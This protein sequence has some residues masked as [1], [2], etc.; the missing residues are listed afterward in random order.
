MAIHYLQLDND[1]NVS[2]LN[3]LIQST[4]TVIALDTETSGL[5]CHSD[6]LILLQLKVS[7]E[8]FILNCIKLSKDVVI[9][10]I[11]SLIV[12]Q[13][14]LVAHN[15]K[16]DI[17]FLYNFSGLLITNI[18]D[19]MTTEVLLNSGIGQTLYSL[20]DLAL[21]YV[22]EHLNKEVRNEFIGKVDGNVTEN[23]IHYSAEDVNYLIDIYEKQMVRIKEAKEEKVYK[24]EFDVLPVIAMMEYQGISLDI[25]KWR[26][27][28][29]LATEVMIAKDTELRDTILKDTLKKANPKTALEFARVLAIPVTTKKLTKELEEITDVNFMM[30]WFREHFNTHSPK[31]MLTV[32]NLLG[33]DVSNTN[34]KTIEKVKDKHPVIQIL[35]DYRGYAK[36]IENYG[37]N[38]I[39]LINPVTNKLHTEYLD[40]G[41]VTGRLSSRNPN[42][43]NIPAKKKETDPDYREPFIATEGFS[44]CDTD[45]S[46]QEFRL[47]GA[48]SK[49]PLIIDA[50][51]RGLDMH[52]ATASLVFKK[53]LDKI[54][55][56]ER[57]IGK[58]INFAILYGSTEYGLKRNLNLPLEEAKI[59]IAE[60][61]A[62]YPVLY[63]FRKDV[64]KAIWELGYSVTLTG[65]RKYNPEKPTFMDSDE[66]FW[67]KSRVLREG[68]NIL[69]QGTAADITK[70]AMIEIFKNNPFGDKLRG[71]LQVHDELI[72]EIHDSILE[73]GK[74]Y[75]E[76]MMCKAEQPFLGNIPAA[77][78]SHVGKMWIH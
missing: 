7:G 37:E 54:T 55:K 29:E 34:E 23:G 62:G 57:N 5:D 44:L 21:V 72:V 68:F 13:R 71:L 27:L 40:I 39:N 65:R 28:T 18:H 45:F 76:D 69:I 30:T 25:E 49:E 36:Q 9:N 74:K 52:T 26:K 1:P 46:Q 50:Y 31:Q 17:K 6:K 4:N 47:A 11:K 61:N 10:V 42:L 12:K 77:C 60:F 41:A 20:Q 63:Q 14:L 70:L 53:D 73:E 66:L 16:F 22:G 48:I 24:I 32:L 8:I 35:L 15:A 33:V 19:T 59:I 58:T 56:Q 78:D 3:R 43:Q 75:I 51:L 67:F 38:I 2:E 64:E